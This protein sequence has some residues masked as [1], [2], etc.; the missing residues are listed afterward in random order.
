MRTPRQPN[1]W[2]DS[3]L[4]SRLESVTEHWDRCG[5]G[6]AFSSCRQYRYALW[7]IWDHTTPPMLVVG[8]NPSTATETENDPTITRCICR[9][10][11]LDCGGLLMGN[12]CAYRTTDPTMLRAAADPVGPETH[13]W[14]SRMAHDARLIV[15]AWGNH[16]AYRHRDLEV[17]RRLD[18]GG[19]RPL[20]CWGQTKTGQPKHPLYLPYTT[21]LQPY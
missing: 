20:W 6:A 14:L 13:A 7:R 1:L 11:T 10:I 18:N 2:P 21:P 9:A 5:M 19:E 3:A 4:R 17:R 8:L 15:C 12:L 16:G